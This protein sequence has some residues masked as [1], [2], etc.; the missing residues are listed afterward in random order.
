ME[1]IEENDK[2][3]NRFLAFQS[4][5]YDLENN[6]EFNQDN[7]KINGMIFA[8]TALFIPFLMSLTS[9]LFFDLQ[10]NEVTQLIVELIRIISITIGFIILGTKK[11]MKK[12]I[13]NGYGWLFFYTVIP[14][15]S[16]IIFGIFAVFLMNNSE[17][18]MAIIGIMSAVISMLFLSI[19]III[20][21]KKMTKTIKESFKIHPGSMIVT[22]LIGSL[23]AIILINFA[24]SY[25]ESLWSDGIAA[26]QDAL[27]SIL[28]PE[29]SASMNQKII[30][31]ILLGVYVVIIAPFIEE[32]VV[33]QCW[34]LNTSNK[35]FGFITSSIFFGFLHYGSTGDFAFALSY[36]AAGFIFGGLFL[37][38][39]GNITVVW[40]AH[41]FNNI[42]AFIILLISVF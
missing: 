5:Y 10:T 24:F 22:G 34:N 8:S 35:W 17:Y 18:F 12:Y 30:Y 32:A 38:S 2:S 9:F 16:Q 15:I 26:N 25:L 23:I 31:A 21:D 27:I 4:K 13:K 39:K 3:K 28:G 36:T 33:R 42:V 37:W 7:W 41:L 19:W 6:F 11:T 20:V 40:L 1:M 29:S 14:I